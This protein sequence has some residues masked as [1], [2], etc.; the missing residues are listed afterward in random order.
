MDPNQFTKP[1]ND[2]AACRL[3]DYWEVKVVAGG[4]L[5]AAQFHFQLMSLFVA[6]IVID[7]A[8]KW[9][10][11]AHNRI[12][13][14]DYT[15]SLLESIK[16]I[17]LAHRAGVISSKAMNTQFCGKIIVYVIVVMAG[18]IIDAMTIQVHS[19]G[20]VMPLCISYLAASELLSII[21][22]LDDAGVS[23]VHDLAA[24]IKRKR[25]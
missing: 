19:Y 15:P 18:S 21:E 11:L 24:L 2:I 1:I 7:L 23:D 25:G 22:N 16:A 5:V 20:L 12:K 3:G 6:L 4:I 10:E 9:I 17:P 13:T 8:T 14:D